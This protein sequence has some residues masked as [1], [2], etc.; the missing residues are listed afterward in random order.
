LHEAV[1]E[2]A[3]AGIKHQNPRIAQSQLR[4]ELA[5]RFNK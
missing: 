4:S 5:K 2:V 3:K 1:K